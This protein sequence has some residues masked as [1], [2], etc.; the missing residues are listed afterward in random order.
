ML[1]L[2]SINIEGTFAG[3]KSGDEI[4]ASYLNRFVYY[5]PRSCSQGG[6]GNKH[7]T[8][9][10]SKSVRFCEEKNRTGS[11]SGV[12]VVDN[13]LHLSFDLND[14]EES[15]KIPGKSSTQRK[16]ASVVPGGT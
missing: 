2:C 3:R 13:E 16:H 11:E 7:A 5:A 8:V 1:E 4:H 10:I 15:S 9:I 14:D 12:H 6:R